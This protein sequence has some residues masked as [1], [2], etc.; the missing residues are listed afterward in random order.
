MKILKRNH[1]HLFKEVW[2]CTCTRCKS[3]FLFEHHEANLIPDMRDGNYYAVKCPVCSQPN[4][5]SASL[6]QTIKFD[7]HAAIR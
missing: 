5:V 7:E 1:A 6:K 4:N 2:P 3:E